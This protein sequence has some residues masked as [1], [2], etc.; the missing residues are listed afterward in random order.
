MPTPNSDPNKR[1]IRVKMDLTRPDTFTP[2][3]LPPD[4]EKERILKAG[5]L[6]VLREAGH[7][8]PE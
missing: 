3:K 4:P 6:R 5:Q 8:P 1:M 2:E 7:I